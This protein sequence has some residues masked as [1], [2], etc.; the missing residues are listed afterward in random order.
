[1]IKHQ[2]HLNAFAYLPE[3]GQSDCG[4]PHLETPNAI[5]EHYTF[6]SEIQTP[7]SLLVSCMKTFIPNC[8][9]KIIFPAY[10]GI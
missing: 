7:L 3:Y 6:D 10:S 1:M 9:F 2:G 8:R 4:F 5:W